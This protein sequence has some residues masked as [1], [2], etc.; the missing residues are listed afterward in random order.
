MAHT[1]ARARTGDRPELSVHADSDELSAAVAAR[2][3]MRIVDV[4]ATRGAASVV[5]TG[6]RTGIAVLRQVYGMCT[7]SAVDW[8]RVNV[9]WSD[10][11]FVDRADPERNEQQAREAL[12]D[13][14][15]VDPERIYAMEARGGRF[16][17]D[18]EAAA[19][20]YRDILAAHSLDAGRPLFDICLL[21][22]GEEGH[23]GSLFPHTHAAAEWESGAVGVRDCPKPPTTRIT[24]TLAS[25]CRADE[26]WLIT[27]GAAKAGAVAT[28][29][30]T[31]DSQALPAAGARGRTRTLW[32][33]DE[34]A[35][36]RV[37]YV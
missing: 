12:L 20:G 3:L 13:H 37:E 36:S 33:V 5:L 2:L 9:F 29:L 11:R 31:S 17:T 22:V 28:A 8:S 14:V 25:I 18:V 34:Q 32:F 30:T 6:G 26:V 15:P 7:D 24:L 19:A 1:P 4:Q 35:A 27:D 10:E 16:G 23:I 21:G